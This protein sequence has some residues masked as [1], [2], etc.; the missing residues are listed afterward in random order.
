MKARDRKTSLLQFL[1]QELLK[2]QKEVKFLNAELDQVAPAAKMS[3]EAIRQMQADLNT[4]LKQV[5]PN[6]RTLEP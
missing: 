6:P 3:L 2:K 4:G 5:P 1:V